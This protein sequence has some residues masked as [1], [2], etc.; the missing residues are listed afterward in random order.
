MTRR[1]PVNARS[2]ASAIPSAEIEMIPNVTHYTFLARCNVWGKVVARSFAL[3]LTRSIESKYTEGSAQTL[4][5]SSTAH[6]KDN[7]RFSPLAC[8][9]HDLT[10]G[11]PRL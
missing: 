6:Y 3:T 9:K 5:N 2:I 1:F 10:R 7:R 8:G 4:S 11:V